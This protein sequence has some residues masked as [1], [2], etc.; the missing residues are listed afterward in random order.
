[1]SNNSLKESAEIYQREYAGFTIIIAWV[2][3]VIAICGVFGNT[4]GAA[5][6]HRMQKTNGIIR[7]LKYLSLVDIALLIFVLGVTLRIHSIISTFA[8]LL[9][10]AVN[11]FEIYLTVLIAIQRCIAIALPFKYESFM[12][13]SVINT[14]L[15]CIAVFTVAFHV[16]LGLQHWARRWNTTSPLGKE[17]FTVYIGPVTLVFRC[18]IPLIILV[19]CNM[20]L[21]ISRR[22]K[23]SGNPQSSYR[24]SVKLTMLILAITSMS[25][26]THVV[27]AVPLLLFAFGLIYLPNFGS[28]SPRPEFTREITFKLKS[29]FYRNNM[30]SRF[31]GVDVNEGSGSCKVHALHGVCTSPKS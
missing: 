3:T 1:M 19:T 20:V 11:T 27:Y 15:G 7:L 2:S 10:M 12:R 16:P 28:I 22:R 17:G 21:V 26:L 8:Y 9:G 14:I 24:G 29:I 25:V 23:N 31:P 6:L 30:C 5:V 4:L 13:A 18:V